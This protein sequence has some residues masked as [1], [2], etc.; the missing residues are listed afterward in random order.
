MTVVA[1]AAAAAVCS[2]YS[3]RECSASLVYT[4]AI[5]TWCLARPLCHNGSISDAADDAQK[6]SHPDVA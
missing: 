5:P 6:S 3:A 2:K 4:L 1:A